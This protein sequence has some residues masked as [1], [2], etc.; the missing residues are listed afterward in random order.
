MNKNP[1]EPKKG[2]AFEEYF[3]R[4]GFR[5]FSGAELAMYFNRWRGDVKNNY[6]PRALW[7]NFLPT[8]RIIDDLRVTIGK[9]ITIT[10]SYR[11]PAYNKAVGGAPQSYHKKFVAADIQVASTTPHEVYKILR[12]WREQG[13]FSG[14]L[15]LYPTFVHV[16]TRG[17]NADW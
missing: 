7:P 11:S 12:L 15:G 4:Q 5:Y 1:Q 10:S 16:D 8:L 17:F 3:D 13:K 14:G 9:P 2:E 6:P